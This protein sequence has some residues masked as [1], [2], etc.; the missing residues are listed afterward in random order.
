MAEPHPQRR[1]PRFSMFDRS[2]MGSTALLA[3]IFV[4]L[5]ITP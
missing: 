3:L 4:L 1:Q 5:I 2:L